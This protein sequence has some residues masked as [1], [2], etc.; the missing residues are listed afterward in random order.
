MLLGLETV[1]A[2]DAFDFGNFREV[3]GVAGSAKLGRPVLRILKFFAPAREVELDVGLSMAVLK[4]INGL[5]RAVY[6]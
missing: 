4:G 5:V 6:S 3:G 2:E 1:G